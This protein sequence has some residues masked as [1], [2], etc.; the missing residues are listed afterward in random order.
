MRGL[1]GLV[2]SSASCCALQVHVIC[3]GR[4][5]DAIASQ[6]AEGGERDS[7]LAVSRIDITSSLQCRRC[8]LSRHRA[9]L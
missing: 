3:R 6:G 7:D 9:L 8:P 1:Q 5:G 4:A 2:V